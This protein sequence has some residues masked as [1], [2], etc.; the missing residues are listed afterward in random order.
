M[1]KEQFITQCSEATGLSKNNIRQVLES[2]VSTIK[3]QVAQGNS[4]SISGLGKFDYIEYPSKK[5]YKP[6]E[7]EPIITKGS[8]I[9][10]FKP[11]KDFKCMMNQ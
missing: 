2:F 7:E 8:R 10:R 6:G 1:N 11:S 3:L 9:P 4:I 5:Y